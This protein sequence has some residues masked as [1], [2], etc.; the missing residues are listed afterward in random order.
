[1][2]LTVTP[3]LNF[4]AQAHEALS[5]YQSVFGGE[6][7][8]VTYGQA[9]AARNE[10][11]AALVLFGQVIAPNGFRVMAYDVPTDLGW[12]RGDRSFFVSLQSGDAEEIRSHWTRL[13]EGA[14]IHQDL[15]PS[16]WSPLY[17]MLTDR[18][19]VTWVISV[20]AY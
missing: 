12:H 16:A 14:S 4:R 15:A 10:A 2:A 1:M 6:L 11:D 7:L 20:A 17:G 13:A 19:G 8:A 3:H 18:F 9:H 5:F